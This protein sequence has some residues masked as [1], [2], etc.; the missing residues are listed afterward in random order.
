[1]KDKEPSKEQLI[2]ELSNAKKLIERLQ[3][4]DFKLKQAEE[5]RN[6]LEKTIKYLPE[7]TFI[8]DKE[9][10]VVAWNRVLEKL[11]G[12][13]AAD[14]VGKSNYEYAIPFYNER[15]P[16]LIDLALDPDLEI[17][18]TY[19]FL[20][21]EGD[22]LYA[23][24]E[25]I[26]LGRYLSAKA[27]PIHDET[28]QIIGA[29]ETIRDVTEHKKAEE[30]S[31]E[32]F[33]SLFENAIEGMFRTTP[34]GR[35]LI[36]NSA[37]A[38]MLGY[39]SPQEMIDTVTDIGLQIYAD[40]ED[41]KV[42]V[43]RLAQEG[44]IEDHEVFF[45]RIDGK[46]IK[47]ILNLQ[48][49]PEKKG[50][51]CFIEGSCIDITARWLAEEAQKSSEQKYRN[52]FEDA[53]V[54]IYQ[55]TPEGRY[56]TVNPAF[57]RIG[58]FESADEMIRGI[59]DIGRQLY[60]NPDERKRMG[61]I[62]RRDDKVEG[63]EAQICRNDGESIWVLI[64]AHTIRDHD[65]NIMY[66]EGTCLDISGHKQA[67]KALLASEKKYRDLIQ[68]IQA[69][70][71]VH[72]ADTQIQICNHLSQEL[73]GLTEE[74]MLGKQAIDQDWHFFR[75]DGTAMP[76]E[77]YPV[78]RVLV[79]RK[80]FWNAVAGVHRPTRRDDVWV[81]LSALP[82]FDENDDLIQIIVT[83][84]DITD[85]KRAE[86]E[87]IKQT[88][89]F[90][91]LFESS[92]EAIAIVDNEDRVLE[93]NHS[94]GTL[95]EYSH[96]ETKGRYINELLAPEPYLEDAQAVS[97]AVIGSGCIVEKEA[98][99]C[100]KNK[101][102]VP[103][104]I[105]G[106]P[107]VVD[108]RQIGAFAIYR[109]I[110]ERKQAEDAL[111]VSL[112]KYH[113]LFDSFP[114]GIT[115]TDKEGNILEVNRKAEELLGISA[116]EH[117]KRTIDGKEW[118]II[119]AD[120]IPM[121]VD[122]Y[123]SS[124]A[125]RENRL[126]DNVEMGI[127]KPDG[128][129]TWINVTAAPIPLEE[130]GVAITYGDIS[131][132]KKA[133]KKIEASEERYRTI[134]ENTATANIIVAE[135]TTIVLANS[136]F[137]AMTGY[138]RQ[139]VEGKMSWTQFIVDEDLKRME[140]YHYMRR[141]NPDSIPN[142]YEYR[143]I[144][145]NGEVRDFFMNVAVIPD[146]R[147]SIAS[148]IDITDRK[149]TEK[150]LRMN[151]ERIQALLK[152]NQMTEAP[153][154]EITEFA[155]E[156]AVRLTESTVGYLAFLDK[157]ETILTMYSWSKTAMEGC[158]I[159]DKPIEYIVEDTGLWGEAVRQRRPVITNDYDAPNPLKRGYPAGHVTIKRHMNIP[160]FDGS[161]IVLVAGVGNK[162]DEY[163]DTDVNQLT[164]L[165]EGM[166]R[167]IDYKRAEEELRKSESNYRLLAENVRDVIW[168]FDMNLGYTYVTPS[169]MRLR[170]YTVEEA[171]KQTLDQILTPASFKNAREI[172]DRELKAEFSGQHHG[173][174]WSMTSELEMVCKDGST[175]WT[176]ATMNFMYNE[177]GE[178]VGIMGVS[179]DITERKRAEEEKARL[180]A[181]LVQAQ[182]MESIGTLAGGIAHDFNNMLAA[183]IGYS[184][185]ALD[186]LSD[187]E[188][189]SAEI[190][191][192]I[193]AGGRAKNLVSQILTFSRKTEIKYS[194]LEL[195][196]LIKESLKMLRSVIP[197]TIDIR[198]DIIKSGLVMSDPTQINQLI[199]NLCTNATHAM[200]ET[201]GV[202]Y[203]SLNRFNIEEMSARNLD[204]SPGPY[205]KLSISDTGHGMTPDLME[206]IFEP[207]FTTK[208]L[209]RGTGLG[210]SVV[211]GIVKSH[212]GAITCKSAPGKGTTFDIY[213][214]ER[215]VKSEAP[216]LSKKEY[217]PRGTERILYIDDEP[218][219]TNIAEKM[220]GRLG[221]D[222]TTMTSSLKAL[223]LFQAN[224]DR[225]DL[226]ITDMTMPNMT[227]DK[228]A[229]KIM[230]IRPD[231]PVILC[232]GYSEHISAEK[233]ASKGIR[234]YVMKPLQQKLL[235]ET[236]RKVLDEV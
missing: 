122:E 134:F 45:Q 231:I 167:L 104:S 110:T 192:V 82:V 194:P 148:I 48:L 103:V 137:E 142:S 207:Y 121:S 14:M 170:G 119:K 92:P 18:K 73:L 68:T 2:K 94:F 209:G 232:T 191:E 67:E 150:E 8:I 146:T 66:Y 24:A 221:Y 187:P 53:Y 174:E 157:E 156:E 193:K 141:I 144:N 212:G 98:I 199:M 206:R 180:E 79:T 40:P 20:K 96:F 46:K 228:L 71:I 44:K 196:A 29:V 50:K 204:V 38:V 3:I 23:E 159:G 107:I 120:G 62:L 172:L 43:R 151:A 195:S 181:Q 128:E 224:P 31:E 75:E 1:M 21:R 139:E 165:M 54:G 213:L 112:T 220:L 222:V 80:P 74:Q 214:P 17:E 234:E 215:I 33:R 61:E 175:I 65:G 210:L 190:N 87:L 27:S 131:Q 49:V 84:V 89:L 69:A 117:L 217:L 4:E 179:R 201:G 28:G 26:P 25:G 182:K 113:V 109:D 102:P 16:L 88:T 9:K 59:T 55:S 149:K 64:N 85:R 116:D 118:H 176:E 56:I 123:A 163:N 39:G 77:E 90:R 229:Q 184:E 41:R 42:L 52:I 36:A 10:R 57:A 164:L 203:V 145:R 219:L 218:T 162:H 188:K 99:R 93:I 32:R 138:S 173:P 108:D 114:L 105:I 30:E 101:R 95:F 235:A 106:S 143:S 47:V 81:L 154:Q 197:T 100:T 147:E 97:E 78:N 70:V 124:I 202:L 129:T 140:H 76:L 126:V 7:A 227:G 72:G 51:P 205:M 171:L 186:D 236:V 158:S 58:G 130:F 22:I 233:A 91:G 132:R 189:A 178:P 177:N 11:T 200:D 160:V 168:I 166:W 155:L 60:I 12:T 34:E 86:E 6:S 15:R 136:N 230:E 208:E 125:L 198:S 37:L 83:F 161:H 223:E 183:I 226:V 135:D 19:N 5:A 153:L 111:S 127:V 13:K 35:I 115:I 133:E 185:L 211:H 216:I 63:F 152:I 169:V 225:F